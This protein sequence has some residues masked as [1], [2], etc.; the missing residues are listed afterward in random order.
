MIVRFDFQQDIERL[1]MLVVDS[2]ITIRKEARA[3]RPGQHSG[4]VLVRGQHAL[5]CVRMRVADHLEQR[6]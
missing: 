4:I 5:R 6:L 3:D 1:G 2:G